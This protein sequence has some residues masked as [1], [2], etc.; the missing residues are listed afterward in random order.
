MET[1][2]QLPEQQRRIEAKRL[3]EQI[4]RFEAEGQV[5]PTQA[6]LLRS[7]LLSVTMA[8]PQSY[9]AQLAA[10]KREARE[11]AEERR[12]EAE[13]QA[14]EFNAAYQSRAAAILEELMADDEFAADPIRRAAALRER[15]QALR[16]DL[17]V[18]SGN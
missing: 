4:R 6:T 7:M 2:D 16:E 1:G 11:A 10:L 18:E 12:L 3:E 5:L 8:D 13:R 9:Q 14:A 15:L 17:Y